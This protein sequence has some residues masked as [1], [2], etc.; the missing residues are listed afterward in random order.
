MP[1]VLMTADTVGGVWTY[2]L[3][4]ARALEPHGF[5]FFLATMGRVL[6]SPQREAARRL[7]NLDI[8]ES[9]YKLEWMADPWDDLS[10]AGQWLLQLETRLQPD[11]IHL[12][13]YAFGSLPW[14]APALVVGHSCVL[15]WWQAVKHEPAPPVWN[16]YRQE[17]RR[18]LRA[19]RLV[20]A[21]TA[22]MLD[23]LDRY[24]G[25]F[26]ASRVIYNAR[27][28]RRFPPRDKEKMILTVG[29]VWDEAKNVALLERVAPRI[30][31][32][33]YVVGDTRH[34]EGGEATYTRLRSLGSLPAGELSSWFGRASIYS[35]P[36][37]YEPFGL[38]ALEAALAG[39]ALVLGDIPSLREIWDDAALYVDPEQP[40]MLATTLNT[41]VGDCSLRR[42][43]AARARERAFTYSPALMAA[44]Y[45]AAYADL[46]HDHSPT[47]TTEPVR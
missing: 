46:L 21:P 14:I 42:A 12:N 19:A 29:R 18:G 27:E 11:L 43:Y 24:Y 1:K 35:L 32:P 47:R 9:H 5:H 37:R 26:Q 28:P 39:C 31:W 13:N 38:S 8:Y 30:E 15:S 33:V 40:D 10:A 36:A 7:R 34:P 23:A 44:G 45:R 2:A 3:E 16:R 6:T 41:L 20:L 22:A 4:V 25:P 17:V